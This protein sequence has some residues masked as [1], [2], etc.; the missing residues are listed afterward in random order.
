MSGASAVGSEAPAPALIL[1][2]QSPR[3]A[4]LL[5]MLGLQFAVVP[6]EVDEAYHPGEDPVAHAERLA[7][8]KVSAVAA[9][10]GNAL[11]VGSDTVVVIDGEV[12]GK[13][14]DT[15]D[16]VQMLMRLEGRTHVVATGVAVAAGGK[17]RSG[18]ESVRVGFRAFDSRT[19]RRYAETGEPMDKAGAYGIQGLGA[20]LVEEI[21]GD[22]YT[23]VGL[24]VAGLL[25][26][27]ERAGW[28][29]RFGVLEPVQPSG[30]P[31]HQVRTRSTDPESP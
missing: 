13:P 5:R 18:V 31:S 7:R 4:Q 10:H 8:E 30:G 1:A 2:S 14:V 9:R 27:V 17:V 16:A 25:T 24:P 21:D 19:A 28:R 26:L 29:Y 15:G 6:P 23:V 11:V 12:L 3:R 22:Y 20:A